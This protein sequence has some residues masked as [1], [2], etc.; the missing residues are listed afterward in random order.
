MNT[1]FTDTAAAHNDQVAGFD[2]FGS[3]GDTVDGFGE[4]TGG[5]AENKRFADIA[6]IKE[7]PAVGVGNTT[8]V[9]AVDHALV[10]TV[11]ETA[12]MKQTFRNQFIGTEG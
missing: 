12:G 4:F 5:T 1:V 9:A 6:V 2:P 8:L 3:T 10:H 7:F 11:T